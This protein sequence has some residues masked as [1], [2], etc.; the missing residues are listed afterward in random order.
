MAEAMGVAGLALAIPGVVSTMVTLVQAMLSRF[1]DAQAFDS[2]LAK[3]QKIGIN[4]S[5]GLMKTQLELAARAAANPKV[6]EGLKIALDDCFRD[7]ADAV[8]VAD[9]QLEQSFARSTGTAGNLRRTFAGK[10]IALENAFQ[11]I[12]AQQDRFL[13]LATYL[14]IVQSGSSTFALTLQEFR[15]HGRKEWLP[16]SD[17]SICGATEEREGRLQRNASET[18][19]EPERRLQRD[20]QVIVEERDYHKN[21]KDD[22]ERDI[23]SLLQLLEKTLAPDQSGIPRCLGY[24]QHKRDDVF[25]LIFEVPN[26]SHFQSLSHAINQKQTTKPLLPRRVEICK[27][28]CAAVL[29]VH[30]SG[31]V[32]KNLRPRAIL[33]SSTTSEKTR[34]YLTDWTRVRTIQSQSSRIGEHKWHRAL[35]QHPRRMGVHVEHSYRCA[36]DIY[37]LGVCLLEIL[38]W[39]PFV[40]VDSE[41]NRIM[42]SDLKQ[43]IG[44]LARQQELAE[45]YLQDESTM[46][47]NG[48]NVRAAYLELAR[49]TLHGIN[50]HAS[51]AVIKCFDF[52]A[53]EHQSYEDDSSEE[54]VSKIVDDLNKA[55]LEQTGQ[56]N[57]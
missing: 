54:V 10:D 18:T 47:R 45:R 38:L 39:V 7:L 52:A 30:R 16:I 33:L 49:T 31:L 5:Q 34:V 28:L 35:Y 37:S 25:E 23:I 21:Q 36:H 3:Y 46:T 44:N 55:S 41:L 48:D 4:L 1:Q 14:H 56:S 24:Q 29:S 19:E 12:S 13:S 32:H 43:L 17:I 53:A 26:P 6:S 57:N 20:I 2:Q 42:G 15:L 51:E 8:V 9:K 27:S 22:V 50:S 40:A 11:H